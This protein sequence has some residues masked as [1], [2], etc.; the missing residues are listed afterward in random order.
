MFREQLRLAR[1][2]NL[3]VIIHCRDAY[4]DTLQILAEEQV[5]EVGGVMHCWAGSLEDAFKTVDLGMHLGFGGTITYKTAD[6]V[7]EALKAVPI[8]AILLETDAPN[9]S[10][11]THRGK[12][13]EPAYV[14]IVAEAAARL[15]GVSFEEIASSTTQNARRCFPKLGS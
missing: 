1:R 2:V 7:R 11:V 10:P 5:Q 15:R 9:L 12:R 13:N 4:D 3:P 8:E 14:S 6:N